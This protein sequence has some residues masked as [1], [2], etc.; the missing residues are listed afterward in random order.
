MGGRNCCISMSLSPSEHDGEYTLI[1]YEQREISDSLSSVSPKRC[2]FHP[3]ASQPCSK[4][5]KLLLYAL[6][7][8]AYKYKAAGMDY[9]ILRHYVD[10]NFNSYCL[11]PGYRFTK[12]AQ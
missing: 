5:T 2:N 4:M 9:V 10:S 11:F 3:R 6:A 8:K 7:P 12:A 1:S